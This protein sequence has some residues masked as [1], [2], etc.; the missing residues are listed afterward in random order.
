MGFGLIRKRI[1]SQVL[2]ISRIQVKLIWEEV[3]QSEV[4]EVAQSEVP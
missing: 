3:A 1:E 2:E 4:P